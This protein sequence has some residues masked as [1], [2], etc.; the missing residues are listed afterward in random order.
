MK[1]LLAVFLLLGS[2]LA[3][4]QLANAGGNNIPGGSTT[5]ANFTSNHTG[6]VAGT[7]SLTVVNGQLPTNTGF[8]SSLTSTTPGTIST[9]C[10]TTTSTIAVNLIAGSAPA[11]TGYAEQFRLL[12]GTGAYPPNPSGGFQGSGYTYTKTNLSNGFSGIPS[13]MSVVAR[14][15]VAPV[16]ILAAGNYVIRVQATVTP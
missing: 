11:Q 16:K 9:V 1:H 6:S 13:S 2:T 5:S 12:N 10:N 4:P 7:C 8:V 3:I 15:A 14:G